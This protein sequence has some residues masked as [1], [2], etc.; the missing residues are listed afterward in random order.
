[1]N[2][3]L[4]ED[5][6]YYSALEKGHVGIRAPENPSVRGRGDYITY[7]PDAQQVVIWDAKYR[8]PSSGNPPK[9]VPEDSLRRWLPEARRAI[10]AL[11]DGPMKAEIQ[12]ALD[13]GQVRGE[14]FKW[15][16]K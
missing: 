10:E 1:M 11:P 14:V 12:A 16:P 9:A 2:A 3:A 4:G 5:H 7:D 6:G 15:P 13:A 8:G